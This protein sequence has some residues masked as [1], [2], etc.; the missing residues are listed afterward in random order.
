MERR[1]SSHRTRQFDCRTRLI[2]IEYFQWAPIVGPTEKMDKKRNNLSRFLYYGSRWIL[3]GVFIYASYDKIL[4]PAAFSKII[5][6]YQILPDGLIN[7]TALVLPMLELIMGIF[8]WVGFWMP[9]TVILSNI[10]LVSYI[11]ALILNLARGLD[12]NCG[13]FS[14]SSGSSINVETI[15]WDAAFFALSVYL[16][17][18]VFGSENS[19]VLKQIHG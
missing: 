11:G 2:R 3:G 16:T 10:L 18:A 15:L 8:F 4:H 12:I 5:Y 7:L 1:R 14:T 17:V 13:C 19:R 9:G 6:N